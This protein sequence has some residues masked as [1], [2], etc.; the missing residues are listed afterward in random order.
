MQKIFMLDKCMKE[1][2]FP[3]Q[4]FATLNG[5]LLFSNNQQ[6]ICRV[7][8]TK[9]K[10]KEDDVETWWE[11]ARLDVNKAM[12]RHRNNVIKT[13][14]QSYKGNKQHVC[15]LDLVVLVQLCL[16]RQLLT[17]TLTPFYQR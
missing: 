12:R 14:Q 4:K 8:A 16:E 7:M 3:R 11:V 15:I 13:L 9:L 1:N 10:I 2:V 5:D 17:T 6:S